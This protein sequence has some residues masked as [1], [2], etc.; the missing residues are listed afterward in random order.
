[1]WKFSFR[2]WKLKIEISLSLKDAARVGRSDMI[3]SILEENPEIM[4][5]E[6]NFKGESALIAAVKSVNIET[7]K[8]IMKYG[9]NLDYSNTDD[10]GNTAI[11]HAAK[12]GN[13]KILELLSPK[14]VSA[15]NKP[16]L[17]YRIL[18]I[19]QNSAVVRSS[20]TRKNKGYIFLHFL[21]GTFSRSRWQWNS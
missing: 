8:T 19:L 11:H 20:E 3:Q 18:E 5:N 7:L 15:N 16:S 14:Y 13:L 17:F 21:L 2:A 12:L 4:I 1:M 6:K 10:K 9:K